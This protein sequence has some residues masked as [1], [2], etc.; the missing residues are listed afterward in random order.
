MVLIDSPPARIENWRTGA[1]G[2]RD[3]AR[4]LR[5]LLSGGWR[6][7]ND[8]DT[9]R[10]NLDHVLVGPGGVF[11]LE[12]KRLAGQVRVSDG[13]LIV[14]WHEDP[15]D[16]Y[17]NATVAVRARAGAASVREQ[18]AEHGVYTWV[19]SVVV[20]WSDF[21]QRSIESEKVGWVRGS[22]LAAVLS[23]RPTVYTGAALDRVVD[24]V[25]SSVD[26]LRRRFLD[27]AQA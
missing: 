21:D 26:S 3:T 8:I 6:L 24:A 18:L 9:G 5:P 4:Q 10:G 27:G 23:Q 7:F 1:D 11:V 20:L 22:E 19:H 15:E 17:E 2:E 14:R 12:S 16:G 13:R 25:A